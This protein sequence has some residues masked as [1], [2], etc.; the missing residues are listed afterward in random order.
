MNA[1]GHTYGVNL[2]GKSRDLA[3]ACYQY[4]VNAQKRQD[5][6]F[7]ENDKRDDVEI[8]KYEGILTISSK[9]IQ[10]MVKVHKR[11]FYSKCKYGKIQ[12]YQYFDESSRNKL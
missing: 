5:T 11:V 2:T 1:W 8:L 7:L 9:Y 10:N 3:F 4:K 12:T 6:N